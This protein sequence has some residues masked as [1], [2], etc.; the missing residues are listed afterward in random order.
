MSLALYRLNQ[1]NE[2]PQWQ[3][4]FQAA[5]AYER[6][7][8]SAHARNWPDLRKDEWHQSANEDKEHFMTTWCHGAPGIAL[9]RLHMLPGLQ[10]DEI[11]REE[12]SIAL[13]TT[14][15]EGFGLN[16][17]LCHGDLGNLDVLLAANRL[18][19]ANEYGEQLAQFSAAILESLETYGCCTGIAF[20]VESPDLMCGIAGIGYG[21]LRLI[22]PDRIPSILALEHPPIS[23]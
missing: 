7:L 14:L 5:L 9:S 13:E 10:T 15:R 21:L 6:R 19:E 17:S 1:V 16:H 18:L 8:F 12:I 11:L 3:Q 22:A 23:H 20:G 4:G 2:D